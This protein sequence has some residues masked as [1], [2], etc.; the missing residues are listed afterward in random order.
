MVATS[1]TKAEA[2]RRA[3]QELQDIIDRGLGHVTGS[4]VIPAP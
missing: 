2:E 4:L 1:S 3:R